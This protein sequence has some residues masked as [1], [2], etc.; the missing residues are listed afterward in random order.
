MEEATSLLKRPYMQVL[1]EDDDDDDVVLSLLMA[2]TN[3]DDAL[4]EAICEALLPK[5]RAERCCR[6]L[7]RP[8]G[9]IWTDMMQ[10][11]PGFP[12][13]KENEMYY[14]H[15]R[16]NKEAFYNIFERVRGAFS[17]CLLQIMAFDFI[18]CGLGRASHVSAA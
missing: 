12:G 11:W 6:G 15:F 1:L 18:F 5:E 13:N 4:A 3:S 8:Y 16:M 17:V 7:P 14:T 10:V 2:Q 9:D